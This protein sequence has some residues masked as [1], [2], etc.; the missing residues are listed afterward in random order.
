MPLL[1]SHPPTHP[2]HTW[3]FPTVVY[4]NSSVY[5]GRG[6]FRPGKISPGDNFAREKFRHP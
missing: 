6:K 1:P 3:G 2:L 4:R 5:R